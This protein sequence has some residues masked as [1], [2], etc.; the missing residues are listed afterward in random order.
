MFASV[1]TYQGPPDQIDEGVRYAQENIM[2]TLQEVEG[3]EGIYLLVD[4]QSGKVLTITLWES[5]EAMRAS[6]EEANQLRSEH[7]GRWDQVSTAEAGGQEDAGEERYE[8]AISPER[9]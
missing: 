6:E 9:S 8:V 3:F 7:R 5:E 2:P 4:R 1:S